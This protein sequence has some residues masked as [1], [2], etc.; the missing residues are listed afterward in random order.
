VNIEPRFFPVDIDWLLTN[1]I[2]SGKSDERS[3][4]LGTPRLCYRPWKQPLQLEARPRQK[5]LAFGS[6][7]RIGVVVRRRAV[8]A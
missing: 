8:S 1:R 4:D 3:S 5:R 2:E 7:G 6:K